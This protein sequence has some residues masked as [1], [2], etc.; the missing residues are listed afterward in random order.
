MEKQKALD[1]GHAGKSVVEAKAYGC[2]GRWTEGQ[3]DEQRGIREGFNACAS[4]GTATRPNW[5]AG[6]VY[7][8]KQTRQDHP[9]AL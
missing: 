1:F 5:R 2:R 6:L 3:R 8:S 4:M 7:E 9:E